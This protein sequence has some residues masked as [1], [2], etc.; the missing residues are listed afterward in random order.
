MYHLMT[1]Y[2]HYADL[3]LQPPPFTEKIESRNEC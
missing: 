3:Y 2:P 1:T